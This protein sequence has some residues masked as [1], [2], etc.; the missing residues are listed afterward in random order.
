MLLQVSLILRD[1][2]KINLSGFKSGCTKVFVG[3]GAV[4]RN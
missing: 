1:A 4:I 2:S 3:K